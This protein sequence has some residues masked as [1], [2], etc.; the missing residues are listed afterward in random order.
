M[1]Y[2]RYFIRFF[3]GSLALTAGMVSFNL[4][5]DPM[6]AFRI[7]KIPHI[8]LY[9]T[10]YDSL[11]RFGKPLQAELFQPTRVAMGSSRV[12]LGIPMD[13]GSWNEGKGFN[14]GI[15]SASIRTVADLFEHVT[16]VSDVSDAL[17]S[18]DL[19]MFDIHQQ[20]AYPHQL[21]H[22][23]E[24]P[25]D[26]LSRRTGTLAE[27]LFPVNITVASL[28]TLVKQS[29][30]H[31]KYLP[32]GQ[33]NP[34]H[35]RQRSIDDGYENRFLQFEDS[36]V[37]LSWARCRENIFLFENARYNSFSNLDRILERAAE[38]HIKLRFFISPVHARTLE[39]MSAAGHWPVFE[40]MKINLVEHIDHAKKEHPSLDVALWDFS[41]YN[42]FTTEPIPQNPGDA[43][44]WYYDSSHFSNELGK[45]LLD[46]IYLTSPS[47]KFG[48]KIDIDNI[49]THLQ[50]IRIAQQE[51]RSQ[52]R[53][54]FE[55]I[56][57]R[58]KKIIKEKKLSGPSCT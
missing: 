53:Q 20:P 14:F 33:A 38:K 24:S 25:T 13:H 49:K 52:N 3:I 1:A 55:Q 44:S 32:S 31:D 12:M 30:K 57:R 39:A 18:T 50:S 17:I 41:G 47:Q 27:A 54:Q 21:A 8:N 34:E 9:K 19:F 46:N 2:Q 42:Q 35:E 58:T 16:Q 23:N 36:L 26:A 51:Y 28:K 43:M 15:T 10:R 11:S 7:I 29:K 40:Q 48:V 5:I 56:N 4:L 37:R 45:V 22:Q 6:D